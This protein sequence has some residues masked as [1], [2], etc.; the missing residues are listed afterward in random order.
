[1][2]RCDNHYLYSERMGIS[3]VFFFYSLN[4]FTVSVICYQFVNKLNEMFLKKLVPDEKRTF[5][6]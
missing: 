5:P 3:E 6:C 1:M 2:V 4:V